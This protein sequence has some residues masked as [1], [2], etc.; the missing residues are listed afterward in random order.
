MDS[1]GNLYGTAYSIGTWGLVFKLTPSDGGWTY[2]VLHQFGGGDGGNLPLGGV[3]LDANG[4]L[5]GT[6][7]SGGAYGYGTLWEITP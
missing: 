6:T 7:S 3:V 2:T 1:A 4:N 5:Y